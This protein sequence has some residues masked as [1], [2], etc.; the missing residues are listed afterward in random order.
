LEIT[1]SRSKIARVR[2][3]PLQA[4]AH[5][6]GWGLTSHPRIG[7]DVS[8]NQPRRRRWVCG[9]AATRPRFPLRLGV[10]VA[11]PFTVTMLNERGNVMRLIKASLILTSSP[12]SL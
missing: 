8:I 2:L 11:W 10:H 1:W 4:R 12:A 3:H 6:D 7:G 9:A 5:I